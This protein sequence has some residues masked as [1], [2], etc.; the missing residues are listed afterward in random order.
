MARIYQDTDL[1]S[2]QADQVIAAAQNDVPPATSTQKIPQAGGLFT[3]ISTYADAA[4][5]AQTPASPSVTSDQVAGALKMIAAIES[6]APSPSAAAKQAL[7]AA[8]QTLTTAMTSIVQGDSAAASAAVGNAAAQLQGIIDAGIANTDPIQQILSLLGIAKKPSGAATGSAPPPANPP[9]PS[10]GTTGGSGATQSLSDRVPIPPRNQMNPGLS[11]CTESA[12]LAKFGRPGDLTTDCSPPTGAFVNRIRQSFDVGPFKVT[13]L[14]YALESL[15]QVFSD[16]RQ[17]NPQLFAQVKNEGMLCVRGRRQNPTHF[18]NHS[19]GTAIDIYFGTEVVQQRSTVAHRGNLLLSPYFN[20]HGWYWGAG[21]SGDSV[22]SMH[23]ELAQ[24][25]I[26]KIPD[27]PMSD[28]AMAASAVVAVSPLAGGG[29]QVDPRSAPLFG[30]IPAL[31]N[32]AQPIKQRFAGVTF[33]GKLS[34]GQLVYQS[35]LQLDTDGWPDGGSRGDLTWQPDTALEYAGGGYVNANTV[36]Y[37]VLPGNWF[38]QFGIKVGDLGAIVYQD[39][40]AFAVFADTGPKGKL[41]E[42]SL[43]LFR[44]VGQERLQLNG[45]VINR[46]MGGGVTTIVFPGSKQP[47]AYANEG[48]LLNYIHDQGKA[49]FQG[50]GGNLPA[51]FA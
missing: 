39:K 30:K 45:Q 16:V 5:R 12:M 23:F 28:A 22:D 9:V 3:V 35:E 2:A 50:L 6:T 24:E 37:F 18:S 13:G 33:A 19:W 44:N 31:V 46:G 25:T 11:A 43:Q 4:P 17:D 32:N 49:L 10:G 40:L 47:A 27:T 15:L 14:D 1:T 26:A 7:D 38:A 36:P 34:T 8:N 48:S 20:R 29:F 41:G 42:A 21:F 51:G